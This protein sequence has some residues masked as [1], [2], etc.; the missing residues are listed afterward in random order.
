MTWKVELRTLPAP[1]PSGELLRRILASRAAGV[2]VVLPQSMPPA[3]FRYVRYAAAVAAL[4][5]LGWCSF[6]TMA[7]RPKRR[8]SPSW[9]LDGTPFGPGAALG[10][11]RLARDLQPRYAL[12]TTLESNRVRPGRW[13]YERVW[14]T[15]G[16]F[17]SPQGSRTIAVARGRYDGRPVWVVTES[18][19]I[20]GMGSSLGDT[21][22]VDQASLRPLRRMFSSRHTLLAQRFMGD[23]LA[24]SL[25]VEPPRGAR[26]FQ[27]VA[28]L[29]GL[30]GSP[31]LISW[32]PYSFELLV[33][34]LPL[35]RGWRASVYSVNW[36]SM[37]ERFPV[38]TPLDLRVA[39]T[40]RIAVPAGVFDCWKLEVREGPNRFFV[41]VTRNERWVVLKRQGWS[42]DSGEWGI[43]ERLVSVDTTPPA[44]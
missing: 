15:D 13:T 5:A 1:E 36:L 22:F 10:Q 44:P 41:W 31:L 25:R 11:E 7:D 30:R 35:R 38:Y 33:E 21:V 23:S 16:L 19:R 3:P 28:A 39:G 43:E 6:L 32:S 2:R 18:R 34:A 24:E 14:I 26:S 17:T 37:A 4:G 9:V 20:K 12:L 27:G 8:A 40:E 42:D 29:P